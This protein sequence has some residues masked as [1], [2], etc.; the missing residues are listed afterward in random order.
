MNSKTRFTHGTEGNDIVDN[1]AVGES[2]GKRGGT[3]DLLALGV[4][5]RTVAWAHEL[6]LGVVPGDDASQMG[7]H[8]VDTVLLNAAVTS[9][10]KVSGLTLQY[11][12]TKLN[13][14][15]VDTK[16]N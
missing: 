8:G 2:K 10:H 16:H 9:D 11:R 12:W 15:Q 4:V 3:A 13:E 7:A 14:C 1:V 5:L 6:V